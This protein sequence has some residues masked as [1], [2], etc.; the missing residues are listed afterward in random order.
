M[1]SESET[2]HESSEVDPKLLEWTSYWSPFQITLKERWKE[3]L[4]VLNGS[5]WPVKN[6]LKS[7][8]RARGVLHILEPFENVLLVAPEVIS[9]SATTRGIFRILIFENIVLVQVDED[10]ISKNIFMEY[11]SPILELS[12]EE[13]KE[14]RINAMRIRN[15]ARKITPI[16]L[17]LL[18][19]NQTA[20]VDGLEQ[21][22]L[23]GHNVIRGIQTL[24]DR[25]EVDLKAD[26]IG[27]W[28][29]IETATLRFTMGKGI[30]LKNGASKEVLDVMKTTLE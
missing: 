17:T 30:L 6:F 26:S 12:E 25:Q 21:I 5:S 2:I 3:I 15:L 24:K 9:R 8:V 13:I 7:N 1:A 4:L 16:K 22:T 19:N 27:P 18:V 20:G 10:D 29:D 23:S 28:I 14:I 11:L